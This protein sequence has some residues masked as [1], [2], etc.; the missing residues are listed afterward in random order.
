MVVPILISISSMWKLLSLQHLRFSGVLMFLNLK[1]VK[2]HLIV[3]I[4]ISLHFSKAEHF[5]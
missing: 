5:I 4:H 3:L 1:G 2:G